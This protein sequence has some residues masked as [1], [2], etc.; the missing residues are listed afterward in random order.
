MYVYMTLQAVRELL[1]NYLAMWLAVAF[2]ALRNILVPCMAFGACHIVMPALR[3]GDLL[4]FLC[5][6][7]GAYLVL[8]SIRISYLKRRVCG[9]ARKTLFHSLSCAMRLVAFHAGRKI[10]MFVV[11]TKGACHLG[12]FT[13]VLLKYLGLLGVT[14]SAELCELR[15]HRHLRLR[16]VRI[17]MTSRASCEF[18]SVNKPMACL[19]LW[20]D[21]IPVLFNR[22]VTVIGGMTFRTI[23]LV[24][25]TSVLQ[26]L[27]NA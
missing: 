23:K 12:V 4:I 20:H 27:V 21:S 14:G 6:T 25:A 17:C 8:C 7:G 19:A 18:I 16:G 26:C 5:M 3:L 10:S 2:L 22:I 1:E 24:L 11:M 9:M 15:T 13:R